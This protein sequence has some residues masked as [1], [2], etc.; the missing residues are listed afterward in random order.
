MADSRII[1]PLP[2]QGIQSTHFEVLLVTGHAICWMES[3]LF[4]PPKNCLNPL[5]LSFSL[6]W[7]GGLTLAR[8][9]ARS[10]ARSLAWEGERE[11]DGERATGR[12]A[13]AALVGDGSRSRRRPPFVPMVAA[14]EKGGTELE[15]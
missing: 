1:F 6:L 10:L 15:A 8:L 13:V 2:S 5:A 11:G 12:P 4:S 14:A 7:H 3:S 9:C